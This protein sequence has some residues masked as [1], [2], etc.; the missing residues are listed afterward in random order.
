MKI[1]LDLN[2]IFRKVNSQKRGWVI[3]TS[4]DRDWDFGKPL[5]TNDLQEIVKKI[6]KTVDMGVKV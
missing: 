5:K 2:K 3:I 6:K 4:E 1:T